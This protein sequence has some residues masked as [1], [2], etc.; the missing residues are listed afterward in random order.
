M[1]TSSA[2]A[3]SSA[4]N[5]ANRSFLRSSSPSNHRLTSS[6][7]SGASS[8][9]STGISASWATQLLTS[10]EF[11]S[12]S[13]RSAFV[14]PPALTESSPDVLTNQRSPASSCTPYETWPESWVSKTANTVPIEAS[15]SAT[16]GE[17]TEASSR[18]PLAFMC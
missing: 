3:T 18:T 9:C 16:V 1:T 8:T 14:V 5:A 11:R 10:T 7:P 6:T 4:G 17:G 2:A 12:S 15:V 13:R